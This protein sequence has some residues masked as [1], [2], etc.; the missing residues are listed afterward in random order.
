M[1]GELAKLFTYC[2]IQRPL[3]LRDMKTQ[4]FIQLIKKFLGTTILKT[5]LYLNENS[6]EL[7]KDKEPRQQP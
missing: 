7:A 5:N 6:K 4:D 1:K 2:Q 3:N